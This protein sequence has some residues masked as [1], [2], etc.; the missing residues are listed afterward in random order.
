[1]PIPC[2]PTETSYDV[3]CPVCGSGFL[4]LTAPNHSIQN[5]SSRRIAC[6][7]LAAQHEAAAE[8][9]RVHPDGVFDL[10]GWDGQTDKSALDWG[11]GTVARFG[12]SY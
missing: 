4:L 10:Q 12:L 5:G 9:A 2:I 3:Q 7:A 8:G 11:M 1:M 6:R